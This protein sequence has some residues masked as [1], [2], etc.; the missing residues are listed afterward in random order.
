MVF[1]WQWNCSE[2]EDGPGRS[3]SNWC[4]DFGRTQWNCQNGG[5]LTLRD[6]TSNISTRANPCSTL[7]TDSECP[8]CS[9]AARPKGGS[10]MAGR[11]GGARALGRRESGDPTGMDD[12]DTLLIAVDETRPGNRVRRQDDGSPEGDPASRI[13]GLRLR[14]GRPSVVA[15]ACGRQV[16]LR[17]PLVQHLLQPSA[18]RRVSDRGG[19]PP[20]AGGNG[21]RLPTPGRVRLRLSGWRWTAGSWSTSSTMSSSVGSRVL[22]LRTRAR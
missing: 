21:L 14:R 6:S 15:E 4:V 3:P 18:D 20:A 8:V 19:P 1:F 16:P 11:P 12:S 10:Y 9:R 5:R 2:G 13:L 17:R 22:P 7:P